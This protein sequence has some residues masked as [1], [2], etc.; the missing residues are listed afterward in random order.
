MKPEKKTFDNYFHPYVDLVTTNNLVE[1]MLEEQK[2]THQ[3]LSSSS[4]NKENFRYAEGKWSVNEV[5][6]HLIDSELIFNYRALRIAR[7]DRTEMPGY[8]HD[9]YV[10][11][12]NSDEKSIM[13]LADELKT[14][15]NSTV[16]LYQGFNETMLNQSGRANGKIITALAIGFIN[17]GHNIHHTNILKEQYN[18]ENEISTTSFTI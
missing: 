7:G 1:A 6:G 5:I 2:N 15:R 13:D 16:L 11:N 8:D 14:I 12:S 18:L 4:P 17:V 9:D 3:F 10:Q